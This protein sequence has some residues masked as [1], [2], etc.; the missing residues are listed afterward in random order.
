MKLSLVVLATGKMQGKVIPITVQE[1]VIGRDAQCQLRPAS[2]L[3]SNRH[4][5]LIRREGKVF[6]R[7]FGSTN[8]TLINDRAFTGDIEV[9]NGDLLKAGPLAFRVVI[10]AAVPVTLSTPLPPT[11]ELTASEDDE[12]ATLLLSLHEQDGP[13]TGSAGI[14]SAGIP[15]G[16]TVTDVEPPAATEGNSSKERGKPADP[17]R[18]VPPKSGDTSAAAKNI[19]ERYLRRPRT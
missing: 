6:V 1:F 16:S 4:C 10:E 9:Q 5:A 2:A 15:M 18:T 11:R 12:A 17:S 19:L 3:I 14:D 8:G 13:V 7:D